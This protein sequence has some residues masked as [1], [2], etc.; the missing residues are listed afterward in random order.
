MKLMIVQ[1]LM[2]CMVMQRVMAQSVVQSQREIPVAQD[3]DVVVVGGSSAAVQAAL[4]AQAAG[5]SVSLLAPRTYLG[6]DLAGTRE[7]Y[8]PYVAEM[9]NAPLLQAACDVVFPFT[10]TASLVPNAGHADPYASVLTDGFK[11]NAAQYSVQY[12]GTVALTVDLGSAAMIGEINLYYYRRLTSNPFNSAF[13]RVEIPDGAGGWISAGAQVSVEYVA[14]S[15]DIDA[16][17]MRIVF[18][19]PSAQRYYRLTLDVAAGTRQLLDELVL[20][21]ASADLSGLTQIKTTP[22]K[23]KRALEAA[24]ESAR[25]RVFGGAVACDVLRDGA[26]KVGGVV[27]ASRNG[28]TAIRA[29]TVIDATE[30]A[31]L[32]TTAGASKE[33]F[34]PGDYTFSRVVMADQMQP[35][36]A[37]GLSVEP[38]SSDLF[39]TSVSGV[40][41]P[42]GQQSTITGKLF[43]CSFTA[44]LTTGSE[45]E[46]LAVEQLARDKTWVPTCLDQADRLLW[47]PTDRVICRT[48]QEPSAQW[49]G[50]ALVDVE[51]YRP[52]AVEGWYVL[53]VRAGVSRTVATALR[54]PARMQAVARRVG[55]A[56]AAEAATRTLGTLAIAGDSATPQTYTVNELSGVLPPVAM[57]AGNTTVIDGARA[58]PVLDQ[59]DVLVVGAGTAGAPATIAAA[60]QGADTVV[61][62]YLYSM[63]GI[64]TDGRIGSYYHGN[65]CGFTTNAVDPGV[66]TTGSVLAQAKSEW[67]RRTAKNAGARIYAG[68]LVA[69]AVMVGQTVQGVVVVLP[70]G[71]RGVILAKSVVDATGN[72]DVAAA[73]GAATVLVNATEVAIQ[74]AGFAPH[75]LGSSYNNT[76]VAF[77]KEGDLSDIYFLARR[78]RKSVSAASSWDAGQNAASR[79]RRRIKGVVTVS[80][81]D[82][83]NSRTY[84]DT[85]VKPKSNFDS[86]G[87]TS[88]DL[89]FVRDP[90]TAS[91]TAHLPYRALLPETIEGVLVTGLGISAHR[92]AM[93]ILRMQPDVQN[94]G[95]AAGLA[96]ALAVASNVVVRN[97]NIPRLQSLLVT[98]TILTPADVGNADSFPLSA[99]TLAAAVTALTNN[100]AGLESVLTDTNTA[101]PLLRA[102]YAASTGS[103]KL[104]YAHVLALLGDGTGVETLKQAISALAW[105]AG[106]NYTGMGQYGRS[107]SLLD[108]YIIAL[109]R[110][111]QSTAL[112]P[113]LS[114]LGQLSTASEFSHV[115]AMAFACEALDSAVA[116]PALSALL[117]LSRGYA[118]TNALVVPVINNYSG[119][120]GD[121]ERN[122]CLKELSLAR[123][124][125]RLGDDAQHSAANVLAQ[126]ALDPR[127]IYAAH[128]RLVLAEGTV[129]DV[130]SQGVWISTA[131]QASWSQTNN[132]SGQG[133]ADGADSNA[134][135]TNLV[136]APQRVSLEGDLITLASLSVDK[137][138]RTFENGMIGFAQNPS[139]IDVA[140]GTV[141]TFDLSLVSTVPVIKRGAGEAVLKNEV[142]LESLSVEAGR[143]TAAESVSRVPQQALSANP[144]G[145]T[146]APSG[147]EALRLDFTVNRAIT[148]TELGVYDS[149]GDG[150]QN[151]KRV[152]IYRRTPALELLLAYGFSVAETYP[153]D[154]GYRFRRLFEPLVLEPGEYALVTFG[155]YTPER[156]IL[157]GAGG[158]TG[159]VGDVVDG[160]G[161]VTFLPG[162][163]IARDNVYAFPATKLSVP[164]GVTY[165]VAAGS[166]KFF[167][168]RPMQKT[169]RGTTTLAAETVLDVQALALSL[170]QGL[171]GQGWIT[172]SAAQPN[173]L[174]VGV[175][176]GTTNTFSGAHICDHPQGPLAVIK[177]GAGQWNLGALLQS[178][179]GVRVAAGDLVAE[180][181]EALRGQAIN[182]GVGGRLSFLQGG[183]LDA[184]IHMDNTPTANLRETRIIAA[185][186]TTLTLSRGVETPRQYDYSGLCLQGFASGTNATCIAVD[187]AMFG[188]V[189]LYLMGDGI[190]GNGRAEHLWTNA[191]GNFR[192]FAAG[193]ETSAGSRV[194][195][196]SGCTFAADYFDL[197]GTNAVVSIA[198]GANIGTILNARF[199][200][201][202][203]SQLSLDGG[204]LRVG[205]FFSGFSCSKPILFNGTVVT[206][207]GANS[208]WM[209]L[210]TNSARPIITAGGAIFSTSYNDSTLRGQGLTNVAGRGA[211][212]KLGSGTLTIA[213]RMFYTCPTLVSNGVLKLDFAGYPADAA[214]ENLLLPESALVLATNTTFQLVGP[215]NAQVV[216]T[217]NSVTTSGSAVLLTGTNTVLK[218][219]E[220]GGRFTKRGEGGLMLVAG[221]NDVARWTGSLTVEKGVFSLQGWLPSAQVTVPY[222]SFESEP[223]LPNTPTEQ[224]KMDKRGTDASGC[225]GWVFTSSNSTD[226]AGYQR[227]NSYW[228]G[229]ASVQTTSGVQT[230]FIRGLGYFTATITIPADGFYSL[231]FRYAPRNYNATWYTNHT[232]AI[233]WDNAQKATVLTTK[234]FFESKTVDLGLVTAGT[235]TLRFAGRTANDRC[236]LIDD[237]SFSGQT[238]RRPVTLEPVNGA[239]VT[240]ASEGK[241]VLDYQGACTLDKLVINGI[242][243]RGGYYSATSFP[244]VISGT[245]ILHVKTGGSLMILK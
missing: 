3:V 56:A 89:F 96:S 36:S 174:R 241:L 48:L 130:S 218:V 204:I 75:V 99:A 140:A 57:L 47:M 22:L 116:V 24:L 30:S 242:S 118:L 52:L 169:I 108:S 199:V 234:T 90:G 31:W 209:N 170:A 104:I 141:A 189:D 161:A 60:Q 188:K 19:A 1:I 16:Y 198:D 160:N 159:N 29:K 45:R 143:V 230:A 142:A 107:V 114:K 213:T 185:E 12:D 134:A 146:T 206:A 53:G 182:L 18:S 217:V 103:A 244:D 51:A 55:A 150:L 43:R 120:V 102:S 66:K 190:Q 9:T 184:M 126:Y 237:V 65:L 177:E 117:D 101:L 138:S 132:W 15:S 73:A 26:G 105:D 88:H 109:G 223:L 156:Y 208:A 37:A 226:I 28:R 163:W 121:T 137:A 168:G 58:L 4:A 74:G 6:D 171:A 154:N 186:N 231:T 145:S 115:R 17:L 33:S 135:F 11:N 76:D 165:A 122:L 148:L 71:Q 194:V 54:N 2:A 164:D 203:S 128:A 80:P 69:G 210:G 41:A 119:T 38:V 84:P 220:L 40:S 193:Y 21:P 224:V 8:H 207:T 123:S 86:H 81:L 34:V 39:L 195:I 77:V 27:F 127:E 235:H 238:L 35:P 62:E 70:N 239:Y 166:F 200:D 236:S 167:E 202:A 172:N 183:R 215:T 155:F 63:G 157:S 149:S 61:V 129:S 92:D 68:T 173:S 46:L 111:G 59:C 64:Q 179:G 125:Y 240:V 153:L 181:P 158:V 85:I 87:Y 14:T 133:I 91:V 93:P 94:Q 10:Y 144:A 95:Y 49:E 225:P 5:A 82:I 233:L 151:F 25:I 44:A 136:A 216:Q 13:N 23:I 221:S 7:L 178:T 147:S 110:T 211:L 175:A 20:I 180:K 197:A 214:T 100:Y 97:V 187:G 79:E 98:Q 222:S 106:W 232:F 176:S 191:K 196:G 78:M 229:T 42:S 131:A 50:E 192:K 219:S 112:I 205:N 212:V 227:N 124:L 67:Y 83:L 245:G 113:L 228:S 72:A 139:V 243:Y 32:T 201:G 162:A 152:A